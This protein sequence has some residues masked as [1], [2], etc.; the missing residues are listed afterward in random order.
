[1]KTKKRRKGKARA[2]KPGA[3]DFDKRGAQIL[4]IDGKSALLVRVD[5]EVGTTVKARFTE[6]GLK[7]SFVRNVTIL[8]QIKKRRARK[9]VR[10]GARS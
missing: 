3:G 10:H 7:L 5:P 8:N 2:G 6:D 1:M 4:E 9:G